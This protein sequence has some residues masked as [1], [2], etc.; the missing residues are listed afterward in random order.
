[1]VEHAKR[2]I[3]RNKDALLACWNYEIDTRELL[4]RFQGAL[5]GAVRCSEIGD[6]W[7][8]SK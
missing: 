4:N 3:E 1:L 7:V 6:V 2:F 8:V 5:I